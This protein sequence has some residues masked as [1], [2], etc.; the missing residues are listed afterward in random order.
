M[1][2]PSNPNGP[3][4]LTLTPG[5]LTSALDRLDSERPIATLIRWS[6]LLGSLDPADRLKPLQQFER[7]L[8]KGV[9]SAPQNLDSVE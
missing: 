6:E 5:N 1:K 3:N 4:S 7:A 8:H 2:P 9:W